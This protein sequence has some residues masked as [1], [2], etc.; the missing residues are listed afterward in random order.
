MQEIG[1]VTIILCLVY[2]IKSGDYDE[3]VDLY[4]GLYLMVD[5]YVEYCMDA[6]LTFHIIEYSALKSKIHDLDTPTYM[7]DL[8][9]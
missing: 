4:E 9:G 2:I 8:L 3:N 1:R 6:P 5:W 7:Q